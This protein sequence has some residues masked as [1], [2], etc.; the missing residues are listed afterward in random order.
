MTRQEREYDNRINT[1]IAEMK[2][3]HW[4][5]VKAD[6]K[7]NV[8]GVVELEDGHTV[9]LIEDRLGSYMH[10]TLYNFTTLCESPVMLLSTYGSPVVGYSYDH[11]INNFNSDDTISHVKCVVF[12]D[13]GIW[14]KPD[15]LIAVLR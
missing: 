14:Y 11:C 8:S 4:S 1:A 10:I 5:A 6:T 15:N 13:G 2:K 3:Y 9:L 7:V 12:S